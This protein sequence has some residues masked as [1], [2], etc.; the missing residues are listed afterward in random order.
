MHAE[1]EAVEELE[2]DRNLLLGLSDSAESKQLSVGLDDA[3]LG[4]RHLFEDVINTGLLT[5]VVKDDVLVPATD[6]AATATVTTSEEGE[7]LTSSSSSGGGR[8]SKA[9]KY[10]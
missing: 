3:G 7:I 9:S 4:A 8:K 6:I 10:L 1:D 2:G 5:G